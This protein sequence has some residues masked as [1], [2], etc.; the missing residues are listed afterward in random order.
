VIAI[1]N[2]SKGELRFDFQSTTLKDIRFNPDRPLNIVAQASKDPLIHKRHIISVQW[3]K[4]AIK[5]TFVNREVEDIVTEIK[6]TRERLKM[7]LNIS[8]WPSYPSSATM[9]QTDFEDSLALYDTEHAMIQ[10]KADT[11][12]LSPVE[13]LAIFFAAFDQVDSYGFKNKTLNEQIKILAS[14]LAQLYRDMV[15]TSHN[16]FLGSSLDNDRLGKFMY[17]LRPHV[18]N[19]NYTRQF[20][21]QLSLNRTEDKS[22]RDFFFGK[23]TPPEENKSITIESRKML[24]DLYFNAHY[25]YQNITQPRLTN[26]MKLFSHTYKICDE[27]RVRNSNKKE[28]M[29]YS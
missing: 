24:L 6:E 14:G 15:H 29:E 21:L 4:D 22:V 20:P 3:I 7:S 5:A 11:L 2:F 10:K 19:W 28:K 1:D 17:L 27:P 13:Q 12:S 18:E 23:N 16:H 25:D 26:H 8:A 9:N